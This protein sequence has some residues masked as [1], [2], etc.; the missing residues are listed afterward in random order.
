[1]MIGNEH[2]DAKRARRGHAFD[3]RD[4]I[5]DS[6]DESGAALRGQRDDLRREP[7]AEFKS[8]RH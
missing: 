4:T 1:M 5:V 2:V 8:I 7:I 3:A 6:N